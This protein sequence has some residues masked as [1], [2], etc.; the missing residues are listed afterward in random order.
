MRKRFFWLILLTGMISSLFGQE[1]PPTV[2]PVTLLDTAFLMPPLSKKVFSFYFREKGTV[3]FNMESKEKP[4]LYVEVEEMPGIYHFSSFKA[5]K[6][7][8]QEIENEAHTLFRF[9]F[10]NSSIAHRY[11][12]IRLQ[13]RLAPF[14][15][16]V[17]FRDTIR[18]T[19]F[20][21]TIYQREFIDSIRYVKVRD[22]VAMEAVTLQD[23]KVQLAPRLDYTQSQ[24][25]RTLIASR[26]P[27]DR[28]V[29]A[30]AYWIGVGDGA[31]TYYD[32]VKAKLPESWAAEGITT[33]L[34]AYAAGRLPQIPSP[35]LGEKVDFA[36]LDTAQANRFY[37]PL[38][39]DSLLLDG[40]ERSR[41]AYGSV[42]IQP[43]NQAEIYLGL[44]NPNQVTALTVYVKIIA[45][46]REIIL[47]DEA[48]PPLKK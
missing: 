32:D 30:W 12:Q 38:Y 1:A 8:G 42:S 11:V 46:V 17:I 33:P 43:G 13:H 14:V 45:L 16:P 3:L 36:F 24:N 25:W 29:Y 22:S 4:L 37:N 26:L 20:A 47:I 39:L 34:Q 15:K 19:I 41:M 18:D 35:N 6:I 23:A 7:E 5:A 48:S 31:K 27:R 10:R 28:E 2:A 21:E 40:P 44:E 9:K